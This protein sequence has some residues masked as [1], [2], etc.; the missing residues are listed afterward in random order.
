MKNAVSYINGT[1]KL[2][3]NKTM[4]ITKQNLKKM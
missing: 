1:K 4:I 2:V 3:N